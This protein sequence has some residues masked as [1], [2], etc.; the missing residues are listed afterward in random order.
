MATYAV[1]DTTSASILLVNAL[2]VL[3]TR[4]KRVSFDNLGSSAIDW[5]ASLSPRESVR[6]IIASGLLDTLC[7]DLSGLEAPTGSAL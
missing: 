6:L 7:P 1:E 2:D 4:A 5:F 3:G